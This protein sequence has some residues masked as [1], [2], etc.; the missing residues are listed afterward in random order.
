[1]SATQLRG[2][3]MNS[4]YLKSKKSGFTLIELMA[5]VVIM[6][7]FTAIAIPTYREYI[8]RGHLAQAQQEMQ[9]LAEQLERH[10]AKNFSYKGFDATY[11]YKDKAGV[12]NS[13]FNSTTQEIKIPI[14]STNPS[15]KISIIGFYSV[16]EFIKDDDRNITGVKDLEVKFD[17]LNKTINF[18]KAAQADM[19]AIG[20]NWAMQAES[21]DS[22]NYKLLLN[23]TGTK[24]MNKDDYTKVSYLTCGQKS[25]GSKIW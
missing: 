15:Y 8:R 13:N 9:K 23:S 19:F 22:R 1:M 14:N 3:N 5:V 25:E 24:C 4:Y 11:L 17:K 10:K 16:N 18:D 21:L 2:N 6:A 20:S 12:I 7:T